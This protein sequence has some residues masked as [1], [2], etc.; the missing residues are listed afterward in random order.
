MPASYNYHMPGVA[1]H[2]DLFRN[3]QTCLHVTGFCYIC[4]LVIESLLLLNCRLF[5]LL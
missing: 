5:P 4:L 3:G 1:V 2:E